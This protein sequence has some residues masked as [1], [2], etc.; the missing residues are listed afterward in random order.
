MTFLATT[1]REQRQTL[2]IGG[3]GPGTFEVG[4]PAALEGFGT[5]TALGAGRAAA[6]VGGFAYELSKKTPGYMLNREIADLFGARDSFDAMEAMGDQAVRDAI[7]YY[8]PDPATTGWAGQ[9]SYGIG[10]TLLPAIGGTLVAGPLGGAALAGGSVGTGTFYDMTGDGVDRRTALGAAGIDAVTTAVGV[11]MPASMGANLALKAGSG[12]LLNAGLGMGQR[13]AM[14]EYMRSAGYGEIAARYDAFDA[15]AVATDVILGAAFGLL[16]SGR[17]AEVPQSAVDAAMVQQ[18]VRHA[19]LDTAPGI[20]ASTA[21]LNAH[22]RAT[23]QATAQLLSGRPVD[24]SGVVRDAEF[25]AR[26]DMPAE[27]AAIV[28]ALDDLGYSRIVGDIRELEAEL[29]GRGI[30]VADEALPAMPERAPEPRVEQV[31]DIPPADPDIPAG[32][33][34]PR[35]E[36]GRFM[37]QLRAEIG[38]QERGG[39]MIRGGEVNTDM[40]AGA[41]FGRAGG[42]VVG[43]TQWVPKSRVDGQGESTM[44]AERPVK[45]TEAEANRALD[46]FAAGEKLTKRERGFIEYLAETARRYDAERQADAFEREAADIGA[47]IERRM[48]EREQMRAMAEEDVVAEIVAERPDMELPAGIV[49]QVTPDARTAADA[50]AAADE[51]VNRATIDSAAYQAAV[52]CFLRNG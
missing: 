21:A 46:K 27:T 13:Y 47:D 45:I 4:G 51:A 50:L 15:T 16:P 2:Q 30:T 41:D 39:K 10:A 40:A 8:R 26:P 34:H 7:D 12:A 20:P 28:Q 23:D 19:E 29:Q 17:S 18:Q 48:A 31:A 36:L 9:I 35:S 43:R 49:E 37:Q 25:V 1:E 5:A 11:F 32:A 52:N 22:V 33:L 42:D 3:M 44:W 38:W 14:G 24:V 6:T